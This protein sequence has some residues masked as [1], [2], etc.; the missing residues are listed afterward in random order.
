MF[1]ENC[2]RKGFHTS[3]LSF[4]ISLFI[5]FL[6]EGRGEQTGY[7]GAYL[8]VNIW[9]FSDF[10]NC[11]RELL[12]TF[13]VTFTVCFRHDFC[14]VRQRGVPLVK[15]GMWP[16]LQLIA[17]KFLHNFCYKRSQLKCGLN[18]D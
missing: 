6:E 17:P 14:C 3:T 5:L 11:A 2:A 1:S 7:T 8:L 15:R 16:N 18:L 13:C 12:D 4:S 10:K 9:Q